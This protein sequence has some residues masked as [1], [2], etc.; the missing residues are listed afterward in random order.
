M[1]PASVGMVRDLPF[2]ASDGLVVLRWRTAEE[3]LFLTVRGESE[4][5]RLRCRCSRCHWIV[6]EQFGSDS[7]R[8]IVTCHNCGTRQEFL[9][10][11]ARLPLP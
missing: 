2:D 5:V 1:M 11:G 9:L 3:G 8:L 7:A 10:E 4:E 6:R